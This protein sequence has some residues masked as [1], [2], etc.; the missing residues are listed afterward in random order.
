MIPK[1]NRAFNV[2]RQ[3]KL[4]FGTGTS[5]VNKIHVLAF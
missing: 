2:K 1:L 4:F 3:L 5:C